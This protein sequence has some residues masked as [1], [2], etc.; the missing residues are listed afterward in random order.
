MKR[1]LLGAALLLPVSASAAATGAT[2]FNDRCSICHTIGGGDQAGPDL[3][4]AKRLKPD[5]LRAALNRMQQN[6]GPLAPA[7]TDALI[8]FLTTATPHGPAVAPP[9]PRGIAANGRR[10]FF[11]ETRFAND[12]T[13]C[14]ACHAIAGE[15]GSLAANLTNSKANVTAAMARPPSPMMKAAYARHPVTDAEGL[16]LAAFVS[17]AKPETRERV[18]VLHGAAAGIALLAFVAVGL[19]VKR[20]RNDL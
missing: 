14:F 10:L 15:G 9:P 3:V 12:G 1:L 18:G 16:D 13:P 8:A 20:R 2:L 5:A 11:G 17:E 4:A 6:V 19:I 7:E